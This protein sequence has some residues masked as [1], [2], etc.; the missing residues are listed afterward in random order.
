MKRNSF[1]EGASNI[2][3]IIVRTQARRKLRVTVYRDFL[4]EDLFGLENKSKDDNL[5][6][7]LADNCGEIYRKKSVTLSVKS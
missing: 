4:P 7:A 6:L 5:Y 1:N 3:R 2:Q